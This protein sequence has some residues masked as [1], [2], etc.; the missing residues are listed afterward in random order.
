[1]DRSSGRAGESRTVDPDF[2]SATWIE[3]DGSISVFVDLIDK[4]LLDDGH[5]IEND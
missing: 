4:L 2:G 1:M 3:S 5:S